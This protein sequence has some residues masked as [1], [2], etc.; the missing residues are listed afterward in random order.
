VFTY[1]KQNI[2]QNISNPGGYNTTLSYSA[3]FHH[4]SFNI[5]HSS[6]VNTSYLYTDGDLRLSLK[7]VVE[8]LGLGI[9]ERKELTKTITETYKD[10]HTNEEKERTLHGTGE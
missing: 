1:N 8:T 5:P 6:S 9:V 4:N 3:N 10:P 7:D 2:Y